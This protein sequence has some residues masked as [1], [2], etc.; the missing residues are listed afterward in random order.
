[1]LII[2]GVIRILWHMIIMLFIKILG[3]WMLNSEKRFDLG[4]KN[5]HDTYYVHCL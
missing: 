5:G 2:N 4:P 1:M 3:L